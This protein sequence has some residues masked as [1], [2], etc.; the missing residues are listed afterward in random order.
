[1]GRNRNDNHEIETLDSLLAR[2]IRLKEQEPL[3]LADIEDDAA[4]NLLQSQKI[5]KNI[6]DEVFIKKLFNEHLKTQILNNRLTNSLTNI[7]KELTNLN[8]ELIKKIQEKPQLL[9]TLIEKNIISNEEYSKKG[10]EDKIKMLTDAI[11]K[12]QK[13][14]INLDKI[15]AQKKVKQKKVLTKAEKKEKR[16]AKKLEQKDLEQLR[17][18]EK[19]ASKEMPAQNKTEIKTG[20]VQEKKEKRQAK[21][22]EQKGL[23]QLRKSEKRVSKEVPGQNKADITIG[24]VRETKKP[25]PKPLPKIPA[26]AE[27]KDIPER[28]GPKTKPKPLPKTDRYKIEAMLRHLEKEGSVKSVVDNKFDKDMDT[29]L[30]TLK[31]LGEE[32]EHISK[33][34]KVEKSV[35]DV[36]KQMSKETKAET[37]EQKL[38]NSGK[39]AQSLEDI[40]KKSENKEIVKNLSKKHPTVDATEKANGTPVAPP[41]AGKGSNS[42]EISRK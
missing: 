41:T 33:P 5:P 11:A 14:Q 28:V 15:A 29:L 4:L 1:M 2:F 21:K 8:K 20:K 27:K 35:K 13:Q 32:S 22:L 18:L 7:N 30:D 36:N 17:K 31:S 10:P 26:A 12:Q 19:R 42:E 24:H 9:T 25:T 37:F 40:L 23:E 3:K 34:Q 38:D 39:G 6:S 16:Q